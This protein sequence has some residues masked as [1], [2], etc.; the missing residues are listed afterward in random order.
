MVLKYL[1]VYADRCDMMKDGVMWWTIFSGWPLTPICKNMN[2]GSE[3]GSV[4]LH[5]V[6]F[7]TISRNS[8]SFCPTAAIFSSDR[9]SLRYS[10]AQFFIHGNHLPPNFN[11]MQYHANYVVTLPKITCEYV[12]KLETYRAIRICLSLFNKMKENFPLLF[13]FPFDSL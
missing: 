3:M 13:C 9:S 2:K 5:L 11:T 8:P 12:T 6:T 4:V 1:G 7:I 10:S